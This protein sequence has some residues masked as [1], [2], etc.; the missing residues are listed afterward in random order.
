MG[1]TRLMGWE[2]W[3]SGW[4]LPYLPDGVMGWEP[5]FWL[6]SESMLGVRD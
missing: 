5:N 3:R 1:T 4:V 2:G 6:A